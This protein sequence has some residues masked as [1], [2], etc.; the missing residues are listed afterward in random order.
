MALLSHAA[1]SE[2]AGW[3]WA[4]VCERVRGNPSTDGASAASSRNFHIARVA[5]ARRMISLCS[6]GP[7]CIYWPG[8]RGG[9]RVGLPSDPPLRTRPALDCRQL[10]AGGAVLSSVCANHCSRAGACMFACAHSTQVLAPACGARN[11][12]HTLTAV[13]CFP[14]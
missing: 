13:P 12:A 6:C 1:A 11:V 8:G 10:M 5:V 3:A 14:W 9:G 2:P 7:V 4:P